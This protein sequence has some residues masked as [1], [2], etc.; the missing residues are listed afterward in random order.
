MDADVRRR[1]KSIAP[2]A[3]TDSRMGGRCLC[4]ARSYASDGPELSFRTMEWHLFELEKY[5]SAEPLSDFRTI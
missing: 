3:E 4:G 2:L 5:G 1:V